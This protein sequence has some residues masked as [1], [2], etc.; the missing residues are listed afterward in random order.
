MQW[1]KIKK[2]SLLLITVMFLFPTLFWFNPGIA[3]AMPNSFGVNCGGDT[4]DGLLADQAY[5]DGGWGYAA[6]F[7]S[8]AYETG[9]II[10]PDLGY[11]SALKSQRWSYPRLSY[12]FTV[13]DG[14]YTV[15]LY[16]AE[17]Y[18]N[19]SGR[20]LMDVKIE[21]ELKLKN[22][23]QY[24]AA[25]GH[26]KGKEEVFSD[27]NV[28]DGVL[29]IDFIS[30][31]SNPSVQ[32]IVIEYEGEPQGIRLSP[33]INNTVILANES[34][35][36]QASVYDQLGIDIPGVTVNWSSDDDNITKVQADGNKAIITGISAGTTVIRA[37][38]GAIEES[39]N[40]T[41]KEKEF[42]TDGQIVVGNDAP[43]MEKYAAR[44]LQR[45]LYEISGTLLPIKTDNEAAIDKTSLVVGQSKTNTKINDFMTA[46]KFTVGPNDPG[47][48][49][50]VLKRFTYNDQEV[51][52]I[53]GSDMTGVL[54]GVYGLLEDYYGIGFYLGGDVLPDTKSPLTLAPVVDEKKAPEQYI[55]GFL[56]WTNFPQSATVYS[57]EDW[58][59][60]IDQMA[61]MKMNL[62]NIHNYSGEAGHNEMFHNF[63]YNGITSLVW[64]AT[65][66]SGHGWAGPAWDV[67]EYLF[68]GADLFDDYDFG[69]DCA[70]HNEGLLNMD[71]FRKGS[72]LFQRVLEYSHS[73]GVKIALGLDINLIPGDYGTTADNPD[74]VN[75]RTDQIINDYPDLDY[76]LSYRSEGLGQQ[77][78]EIW[79]KI[80]NQM[81]NRLK[82]GA[83][84]IRTGV[85]GWGIDGATVGNLPLD[86][87]IAPI[88]A[89]SAGFVSGSEYGNREYWGC[90]WLERDFNSS[91][92]YYP[93][94]MDLSST[95]QAYSQRAPNM[96]GFQCL[97]W[98]ITDAVDAKMSYISKAPWDTAG[99]YKTS[100]DVYHE[101][102]V[103]NYG[104]A[105]ADDIT[106]IINQNEPYAINQSECEGTAVF[107]GK[108]RTNDINKATSQLETIDH[109][110]NSTSGAGVK[111]RLHLLRSRIEAVKAFDELDQ[112]F[113]TLT[114]EQLPGS[115][116]TWTRAFIERVTDISSLGNVQS[117]QNRWVQL[118][119]L[120]KENALRNEQAVKA[121]SRVEARG[122]A[123]GAAITWKNEELDAYGF[124]VY[125]DGI[126][127]NEDLLPLD[128]N[129]YNDTTDG[130]YSYTVTV[131][132]TNNEESPKSVP[133]TCKAGSADNDAPNII[134]ISPPTSAVIG[135]PVDVEA[136]VLDN[137][138]YSSISAILYYRSLGADE[139]A[140]I[141]MTR[142]SRAIFAARIP[143][144]VVTAA[145]LEYYV[146]ASDGANT[147]FFPK[148]APE[149]P[150]SLVAETIT[151]TTAPG[152]PGNPT[153]S[154]I[155]IQWEPSSGDVFWY[156]I[157]RSTNSNFTPDKASFVS[158]VYKD[159]TSFVDKAGDFEGKPLNGTY[160][161]KITA[162]DKSGNE[163]MSS[164]LVEVK[165]DGEEN[166]GYWKFDEN[167]GIIA[168]D[169]KGI[170]DG[171]INGATWAAGLVNSSLSFDGVDDYVSIMDRF[172]PAAYTIAAWVKPNTTDDMS[173]F[174]RTDANGPLASWSHQLRI[175]DGKF[176]SYAYDGKARSVIGTTLIEPGKW[177]H[178]AAVVSN[179]GQMKLYVNGRPEGTPVNVD[180]LWAGGDRY[181]IG[182]NASGM[183][184]FNGQIDEVRLYYRALNVNEIAALVLAADTEPPTITVTGIAEDDAVKLNQQVTVTW[185]ASDA[186]SGIETAVGDITSGAALDT[187]SV[188][189]H[190]LTFTATDKAGNTTT[191][192]ITYHV[193]Y[194][195]SGVHQPLKTEGPN[196]FKLGRTIPVKFQLKDA[197]G[198]YV[199]SAVAKLYIASVTDAV[200]G[201][202]SEAASTA[203]SD[204]NTFRYDNIENQYIFNLNTRDLQPGTYQIRIDLG[205]GT[206][207]TVMI[208]LE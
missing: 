138:T 56:P 207:N 147:G 97:T 53:A 173:I 105:A 49:G 30:V 32:A 156:K 86:V 169:S 73:R 121:P 104:E 10:N 37:I 94:N 146:A 1:L 133:S 175:K 74:V 45:Y 34:L 111:A 113:N 66:K 171:T 201:D 16:F 75:A 185:E 112:N 159:T 4:V 57:W 168:Y 199:T 79:E 128:T 144:S 15:K 143:E 77:A 170:N 179:G 92:Y 125:R 188:G 13:P 19:E 58:K 107:T 117:S 178:V 59:F 68:G 17:S 41:I 88:S 23:D 204:G 90:P 5:Q 61:K 101:Y 60:I 12:K 33:D 208:G 182:S 2:I 102:A 67:K 148:T 164:A 180:A 127:L 47:E 187:S 137:R 184:Y 43:E 161:Y 83:P 191:K 24:I 190:T 196:T 163:S 119:Y 186:L 9:D 69:A 149:L 189:D 48:Q 162:V 93:Y 85:S 44:E 110:I 11:P 84:Q 103:K 39:I 120:A 122:T 80:F 165:K 154:L 124:N 71:V 194:D 18:F 166:G 55:R 132:N 52:A 153:L 35:T 205:D 81:Y 40:I 65:A 145:G 64:N 63:T 139:Y 160:Y 203:T 155:K 87:I 51:L 36:M 31:I 192:S 142:R 197:S 8:S 89:Y 177:Y 6:D 20:R 150:M 100:Y 96:K 134:V 157:Y 151:D 131:V 202:E 116:D 200:V 115:F 176:E 54:Y 98:R 198:A 158:Y 126:K 95:I 25:G 38:Y 174:V 130:N 62:L 141:P 70:L 167:D 14:R 82:T 99:K 72:S 21:E 114:W 109:W 42:I 108:D 152:V 91:V 136:R 29:N 26:D 206:K 140:S 3:H 76:L 123:T 27:I 135:Q 183:K 28:T 129:S 50:Y 22:Y 118:R 181:Y 106:T 195:F 7:T 46:G 193:Q 172:D 78:S